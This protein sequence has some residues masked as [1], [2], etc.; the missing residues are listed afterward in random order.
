MTLFSAPSFDDGWHLGL[1]QTKMAPPRLPRQRVGRDHL[2]RR[3]QASLAR[4]L[5]V[6]SAPAGFG[7]TTLLT[8]WHDFLR[9]EGHLAAWLTL[10]A[11]DNDPQQ[12]GSYLVAALQHG[13]QGRCARSAD[14]LRRDPFTPIRTVHGVLL[15]DIAACP[16]QVFLFLD[17]FESLNSRAGLAV[18]TRLL[19]YAPTNLHVLVGSRREPMLRSGEMW[20]QDQVLAVNAD[21]LRFSA[22]D[23]QA[24][25]GGSEGVSLDRASV[26]LLNRATEGWVSGLQLAA[27]AL[28][29]REDTQTLARELASDH[30]GIDAYLDAAVLRNLPD[31]MLQFLLRVSIL[32]RLNPD[33]CDALVGARH[34]SWDKLRWLEDHHVFLQALDPGR[35]WFRFHALMTESLRR[36]AAQRIGPELPGLHRRASQWFASQGMWPDAIHHALQ[37]GDEARAADWA[38]Q[39]AVML[40]ARSDV[41]ALLGWFGKL[42]AELIRQRIRL[43][44]A[45]AWALSMAF[46]MPEAHRAIAALQAALAGH[47]G[48][49]GEQEATLPALRAEVA[50]M[51]SVVVAWGDDSPRALGLSTEA[52]QAQGPIPTWARCFAEAAHVFSLAY[53]GRFE[54][55]EALRAQ[56]ACRGDET[57][58]L[59]ASTYHASMLALSALVQGRLRDAREQFEA[60]LARAEDAVGRESAAAALPM[61]YL[62]A[63]AYERG[64]LAATQDLMAGRTGVALSSC[65]LGS[66]L[67][68]CWGAARS[69][70]R[71]GDLS[72]A[73]VLL[74]EARDLA[75]ERGW[76]RLRVGSDAETVRLLLMQGRVGDAR[77]VVRAMEAVLP[78]SVVSAPAGSMS[79][80]ACSWAFM[81]ARLALA[82]GRL[83]QAQSILSDASEML[84]QSGQSHLRASTQALLA[85]VMDKRGACAAAQV[86][87]AQ[88][89]GYAGHEP[90]VTRFVDEGEPMLA[91]LRAHV[92]ATGDEGVGDERTRAVATSLLDWARAHAPQPPARATAQPGAPASVLSAREVEI[93]QHIAQGLSNK[94]VARALR[95]APETIKWHLKNVF[96]KLNVGSRIEAVQVGL[97]LGLGVAH[98]GG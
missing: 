88:A 38:E 35:T 27:L 61:G 34:R 78:P 77:E 86:E 28:R 31:A 58:P 92:Q 44:V 46:R 26:E 98:P 6:V 95:V 42:P 3:L 65:P 32:D 22:D 13:T 63:L 69:M 2:L 33:A 47:G 67:R 90:M 53:E 74:E 66:V 8:E 30:F 85:L 83:A 17:D 97:G 93:L 59:Y 91:L 37:A 84:R 11:D 64:D 76:L 29:D 52:L 89:L 10:D 72:G 51:Y 15:N 55:V 71:A 70:V 12:L 79:E 40:L 43:Q 16:E 36:R 82:E 7:K 48:E 25:F 4:R 81:Q 19:R 20:V 62:V 1:I 96:D 56:W 60:A 75:Q 87:L 50:G 49:G 18:V 68:Y 45:Q 5:T 21:D 54:A 39:G 41:H 24:F 14:L 9:A 80:T 57:L 94:Q 73:L 23:A